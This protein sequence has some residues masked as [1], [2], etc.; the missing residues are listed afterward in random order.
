MGIFVYTSL[1]IKEYRL[2][3]GE[4][5]ALRKDFREIAKTVQTKERELVSPGFV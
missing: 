3:A 2:N 4:V 5:K 1:L